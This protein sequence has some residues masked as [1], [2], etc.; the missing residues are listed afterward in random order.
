MKNI[1][2][3]KIKCDNPWH[4][5]SLKITSYFA[6]IAIAS[7]STTAKAANECGAGTTITCN[8]TGNPYING[9]TYTGI[10][11]NLTL[12][13]NAIVNTTGGTPTGAN[14][15]TTVGIG[16]GVPAGTTRR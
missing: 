13:S 5:N 1:N 11:N 3:N 9:I 16:V 4:T 14:S 10:N 12:S 7:L 6:L 8:N 2:A 15:T